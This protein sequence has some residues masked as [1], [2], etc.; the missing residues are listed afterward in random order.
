MATQAISPLALSWNGKRLKPQTTLIV[1]LSVAAH[2]A[3]AAYLAMMQFAPPPVP[4]IDEPPPIDGRIFRPIELV[5]PKPL[6]P[7]KVVTPRD[8]PLPPTTTDMTPI[9]IPPADNPL[10][11]VAPPTTI[12]KLDP[13]PVQ[14]RSA[15]DPVIG[16]PSWLRLPDADD[17]ARH[18]PDQAVRLGVEGSATISCTV[19]ARG[20]I[21]GC[22][23]VSET[24]AGVGFGDAAVKLSRYFRMNPKTVDGRAVEGGVVRIPIRFQ[25]PRA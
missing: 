13:P 9:P 3:V 19:T 10:P 11:P 25:L 6:D 2:A 4:Q 5:P 20:S 12:A 7:P 23:V 8:T 16:N 1:G 24:P 14:T 18:Y 17:L 21:G 15:P 22:S